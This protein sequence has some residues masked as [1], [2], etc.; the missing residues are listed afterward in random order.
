MNHPVGWYESLI[1][2]NVDLLLIRVPVYAWI[3]GPPSDPL[4][5]KQ[6]G[7]SECSFIV[8]KLSFEW[9]QCLSVI[10][11][12]HCLSWNRALLPS[13]KAN[14]HEQTFV[15]T[16]VWFICNSIIQIY[17]D[18]FL[19]TVTLLSKH[20]TSRCCVSLPMPESFSWPLRIFNRV[21]HNPTLSSP[22]GRSA[23]PQNHNSVI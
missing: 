14:T 16:Q 7:P 3:F 12:Y 6:S 22:H 13:S 21:A 1:S 11:C 19:M 8:R 4:L 15:V 5:L 2:Q 18:P 9:P 20:L 23:V 17:W 10:Q